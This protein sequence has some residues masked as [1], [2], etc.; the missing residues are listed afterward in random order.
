[1]RLT[2]G[3][4]RVVARQIRRPSGWL[5]RM[6]GRGMARGHR[7]QTEWALKLLDIQPTDH[8]LDVGCGTGMATRIASE[9][10]VEGFVAAVDHSPEMV[11]EARRRNTAAIRNGR[12]QVQHGDVVSLPFEEATFDKIIGIET[13]YFWPDP[14]AALRELCRVAKPGGVIALEMENSLEAPDSQ[15]VARRAERMG[16]P[17]FSGAEMVRMLRE[18]GFC[19]ARFESRPNRGGGWLCALASKP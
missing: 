6:W 4:M 10:A 8:V 7:P 19:L 17:V 15:A 13:F 1:M 2:T 5:G 9:I 16:F 11:Q 18:A 14:I 12:V 3:L